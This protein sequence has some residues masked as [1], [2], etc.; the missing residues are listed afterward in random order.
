[1]GLGDVVDELLNEDSLADTGTAEETNLAST[2]VRG[3]Q[4]DDLDTGL[5][6]LGRGRLVDVRGRVGVDREGLD[7]LDRATLVDRLADN[8]DDAAEATRSDGDLDGRARVDDVLST[9]ETLGTCWDGWARWSVSEDPRQNPAAA[10]ARGRLTV[11]GDGADRV[12]AEVHSDLENET[13]LKALNLESVQDG[14]EVLRVELDLHV[15]KRVGV[16]A[17]SSVNGLDMSC[18]SATHG[19]ETLNDAAAERAS[20]EGRR[21]STT[22]PMTCLTLPT[23]FLAAVAYERADCAGQG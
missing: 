22:A 20:E 23:W 12:L 11:H 5:E 8:V 17:L 16:S 2:G 4:V 9:D 1:M 10:A 7:G 15:F 6:D 18:T 19:V 21:T 3:E 14:R 13:V